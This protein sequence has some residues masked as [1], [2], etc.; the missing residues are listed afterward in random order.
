MQRGNIYMKIF[1]IMKERVL[2]GKLHQLATS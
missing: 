1:G 2:T